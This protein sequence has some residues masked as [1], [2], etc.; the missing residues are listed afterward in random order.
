MPG[1]SCAFCTFS[2]P[3]SIKNDTESECVAATLLHLLERDAAKTEGAEVDPQIYVAHD[4]YY[5]PHVDQHLAKEIQHEN[6]IFS[7]MMRIKNIKMTWLNGI[8]LHMC[9]QY[10]FSGSM[11]AS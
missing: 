7:W 2:C 11:Q 10:V 1:P 5:R 6:Y 9:V 4:C 8:I 3:P